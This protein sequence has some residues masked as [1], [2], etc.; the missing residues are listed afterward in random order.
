MGV[1]RAVG[2]DSAL[3]WLVVCV[4]KFAMSTDLERTEDDEYW[5]STGGG[6]GVGRVCGVCFHL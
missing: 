6:G 2:V 1:G 4:V 5:S 3:V